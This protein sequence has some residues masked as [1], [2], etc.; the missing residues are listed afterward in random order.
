MRLEKHE[1]LRMALA[2]DTAISIIESNNFRP[3]GISITLR[4]DSLSH[5]R[6]LRSAAL[7]TNREKGEKP[8]QTETPASEG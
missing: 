3:E 6:Y 5:L 1:A 2:L 4:D 7:R 8:A